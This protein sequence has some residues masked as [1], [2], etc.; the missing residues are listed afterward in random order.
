M[1]TTTAIE[2]SL[3]NILVATDFSGASR[4]ALRHALFIAN[5]N[6]SKLYLF[7]AVPHDRYVRTTWDECIT[8]AWH[9][10][11][12]LEKELL[13]EGALDGIQDEVIVRKG[14]VW[15]AMLPVIQEASIDLV[16]IGTHGRAG[17]RKLV[18][19]SVAEKVFRHAPCPVL[20]VGPTC[21]Y[22]RERRR[23]WQILYSTD[24]SPQSEAA[25]LYAG[26]LTRR[27]HARLA[28]LHVLDADA[29]DQWVRFSESRLREMA[30]REGAF[31]FGTELLVRCGEPA[32]K[33]LEVAKEIRA[34]LI[35]MGVRASSGLGD[36]RMW[37]VA[38]S[39]VC[40]SRCP[41]LTA[42]GQYAV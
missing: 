37:P 25:L 36:H 7:H 26:L 10:A 23:P 22:P 8:L 38:Y 14:G 3:R 21:R 2:V 33:I 24:F 34:D 1:A 4:R 29:N 40:G 41:V 42:R 15:E 17:L 16:V 30:Q 6:H 28:F 11:Q 18:L 5:R 31:A 12:D 35:V 13:G 27:T 20:T 9:Q 32:Q 39:I 19:G